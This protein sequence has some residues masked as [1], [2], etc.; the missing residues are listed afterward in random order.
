M[1]AEIDS[2]SDDIDPHNYKGIYFDDD[3]GSKWQDPETGAHFKYEDMYHRLE[4][5]A[6]LRRSEE[7]KH[8]RLFDIAEKKRENSLEVK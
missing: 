8:D 5:V 4:K 7:R 2:D 6:A 3:P 1:K